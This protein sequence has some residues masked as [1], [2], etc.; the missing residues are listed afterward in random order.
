MLITRKDSHM[1]LLWAMS[2]IQKFR[3][4]IYGIVYEFPNVEMAS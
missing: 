3:S 2:K 4:S 1:F